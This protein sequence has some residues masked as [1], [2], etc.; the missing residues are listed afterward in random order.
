MYIIKHGQSA[1][2]TL[3]PFSS[4]SLPGLPRRRSHTLLVEHHVCSSVP[5]CA[6][7]ATCAGTTHVE[8]LAAG[9]SA[10]AGSCMFGH[11]CHRAP[12]RFVHRWEFR[13][14]VCPQTPKNRGDFP[15]KL[16][17]FFLNFV[18]SPP[19][20]KLKFYDLKF[21]NLKVSKLKVFYF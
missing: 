7:G 18:E 21:S 19:K 11:L 6:H 14:R 16:V 4:H 13:D 10:H 20:I 8:P 17:D 9:S 15:V 3:C 5:P 12:L 2:L 1:S